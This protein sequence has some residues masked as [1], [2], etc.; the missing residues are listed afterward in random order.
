MRLFRSNRGQIQSGRSSNSRHPR[1]DE[2][3]TRRTWRTSAGVAAVAIGLGL[4]PSQAAAHETRETARDQLVVGWLEE[5]AFAGFK[6]AVSLRVTSG[7]K[8]VENLKLEV[9]VLFGDKDATQK[10]GPLELAPSFGDPGHY[11]APII[12]TEPGRYTFH[13]TG[14]V[15]R[16]A[17]DEYFTSGDATFHDVIEPAELQFPTKASSAVDLELKTDRIASRSGIAIDQ[18]KKAADS[19]GVARALGIAALVTATAGLLIAVVALRRS[20]KPA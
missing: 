4:F 19:A 2:S 7:G 20:G 13:V 8:G 12:P 5:P 3:A 15:G 16:E 18:A 10:I 1:L 11:D 9:E 17:L 14:Q 6:N